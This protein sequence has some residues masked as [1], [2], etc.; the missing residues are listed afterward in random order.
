MSAEVF[1]SL[2]RVMAVFAD[3]IA[4]TATAELLVGTDSSTDVAEV[5]H[6]ALDG[7]PGVGAAM[8][9]S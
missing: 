4:V 1:Q 9:A 3:V 7:Q 6:D 2:F 8:S 5:A